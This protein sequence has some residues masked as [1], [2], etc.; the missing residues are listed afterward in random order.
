MKPEARR[1]AVLRRGT[2]KGLIGEI[3]GGG[4]VQAIWG[5]GARA[6]WKNP[7]KNAKKNITSD[8]MN[9]SIPRRWA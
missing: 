3:P 8:V 9:S 2:E 6:E 4:Q 5:V 7:Q 1:T